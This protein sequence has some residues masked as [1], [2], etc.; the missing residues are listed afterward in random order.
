MIIRIEAEQDICRGCQGECRKAYAKGFIPVLIE[1]GDNLCE[2]MRMCQ[3]ERRRREQ[4]KINR[5]FKSARV[6]RIY[7]N[8]SFDDYKITPDNKDA[9]AA[10]KWLINDDS[11]RGLFMHGNKGTGKTKLAAIIANERLRQGKPVLFESVPDLMGDIRATFQ[12][13][14]TD[15]IIQSVKDVEFLVLDDLG[16]ERMTEWI[17]EQLFSI[18]NHRYNERLLTVVTSN[19]SPKEIAYRM[20]DMQGE[21]IMSRIL[22]MCEV[23]SLGGGDYRLRVE[24]GQK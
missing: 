16:A 2:S 21:R 20:D 24:G 5:L 15:E 13:G 23:V 7:E 1:N 12:K 6:P 9:V 8:D 17:G 22:G 10:A 3:H 19:Y 18:V 4:A 11:G 14:G